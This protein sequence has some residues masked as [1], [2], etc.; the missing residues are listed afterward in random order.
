MNFYAFSAAILNGP[1]SRKK[2]A[3]VPR[4]DPL[5]TTNLVLVVDLLAESSAQHHVSHHHSPV[6]L[7]Q[8]LVCV[9]SRSTTHSLANTSDS[10]S[11]SN[12]SD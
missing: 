10:R 7:P 4:L 1:K 8:P 9:A 5:S 2:T 6:L 11:N 3:V 12:T